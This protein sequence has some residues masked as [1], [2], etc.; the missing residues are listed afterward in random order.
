MP[1]PFEQMKQ[2]PVPVDPDPSFAARLRNLIA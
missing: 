1:D 2:P